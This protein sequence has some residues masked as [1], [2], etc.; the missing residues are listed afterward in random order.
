MIVFEIKPLG[1]PRMTQR[2]RW[3]KRPC[4]NRYYAYKD[5]LTL[6]ANKE[7]YTVP[8]KLSLTFIIVL[9]NK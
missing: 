5:H 4:V 1:K 9:M 3:A 2:D 6:L 7:Q 8:D